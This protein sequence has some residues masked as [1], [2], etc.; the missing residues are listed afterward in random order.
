MRN[1]KIVFAIIGAAIGVAAIGYAALITTTEVA[2]AMALIGVV[3]AVMGWIAH[4]WVFIW[5]SLGLGIVL[6]AVAP[7]L[8]ASPSQYAGVAQAMTAIERDGGTF[9]KK[10]GVINAA[11]TAVENF[12]SCSQHLHQQDTSHLS[13]LEFTFKFL[14]PK[15]SRFPDGAGEGYQISLPVYGE[16]EGK[17]FLVTFVRRFDN[18]GAEQ[19]NTAYVD[20]FAVMGGGQQVVDIANERSSQWV[21]TGRNGTMSGANFLRNNAGEWYGHASA[22]PNAFRQFQEGFAAA[23]KRR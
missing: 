22:F 21:G 15:V 18:T 20:V 23:V 4:R 1:L 13:K 11:A 16:K 2:W 10:E 6:G 8:A 7:A 5:A 19:A 9:C 12:H 3:A 14:P 17:G